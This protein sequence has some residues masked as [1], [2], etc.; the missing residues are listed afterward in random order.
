MRLIMKERLKSFYLSN[1]KYIDLT[2]SLV[3]VAFLYALHKGDLKATVDILNI[4]K[5]LVQTI[6]GAGDS[7]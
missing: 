1:R 6:I 7:L 5:V 3:V 2:F 4:A